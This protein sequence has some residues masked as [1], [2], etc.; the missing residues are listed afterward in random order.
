[1]RLENR[2]RNKTMVDQKRL[3]IL[4]T[5]DDGIHAEGLWA[6]HDTI[7]RKHNVVVVA[8]DRERSAVGHGITLN[9]PIRAAH[10]LA[11]GGQRGWAVSGTPADCI[12]LAVVELLDARPDLVISGINPGANVGVNLNYSGT[13]AAAKEAAL[14]GIPSMAVSVKV[15]DTPV[16]DLAVQF[17][18]HMIP[19]IYANGLPPGI[20]LNI[21]VPHLPPKHTAGVSI[22]RQGKA[23][24]DDYFDK[25]HDPRNRV[26]YW[27]G[28]ESQPSYSHSDSDGAVLNAD[29][30]SVTPVRCD[31]T[32][33]S[34][35]KALKEWDFNNGFQPG[36][37]GNL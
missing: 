27:Q 6:V 19:L 22:T 4:L 13:V 14:Y 11:N 33:Q 8:P 23:L 10:V 12:K 1:M 37:T 3:N 30:I 17:I 21:N 7:H 32:D 29:G 35:L 31:M 18:D 25:R 5:N 2:Y 20:F 24:Y 16:Y 28:S 36:G 26:Y 9:H 34:A 15:V